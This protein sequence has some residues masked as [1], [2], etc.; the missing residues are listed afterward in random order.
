MEEKEKQKMKYINEN[1]LEKGYNPEELSNFIIKTIGIPIE[2][3]PF[4]KL[5]EMIEEFKNQGLT[6]TYKTIKLNEQNQ[7]KKE[8][9][10]EENKKMNS[11]L[12][13]LYLPTSYE[14]ETDIQQEKKPNTL[15]LTETK[16]E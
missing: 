12:Y 6:E 7:K 4:E 15:K 3:L 14:I 5:K 2:S 13:N 8:K 16:D 11:P 1:I 10:K 9:E